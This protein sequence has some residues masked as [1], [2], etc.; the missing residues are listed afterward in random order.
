MSSC[1]IPTCMLEVCPDAPV[2]D[3]QVFLQAW[4][5][6]T[7]WL[8]VC[9][10]VSMFVRCGICEYLK[11]LIDQTPRNQPTL[12][13][14]LRSRL[15]AHF[16]FQAAQRLAQGRLEE[17]CAQSAGRK[18]FMK[19]DKMDQQK[20]VTPTVWSQLATPLF[21]DVDKRLVT[22]LIGSMWHGP[23]YTTHLVRSVFDDC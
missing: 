13:D 2:A 21:R 15:G 23:Q 11:L 14:A 16:Q 10:S 8:V 5:I 3:Y 17:E 20:T 9:K 6:E 22:G 1:L 18:W 19:I 4:R 7:P 12:R